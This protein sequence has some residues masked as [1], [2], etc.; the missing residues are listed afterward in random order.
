M[1]EKTGV[2]PSDAGL[3]VLARE[4]NYQF[5]SKEDISVKAVYQMRYMPGVNIDD[6]YLKNDTSA[7]TDD[8]LKVYNIV[9]PIVKNAK[10]YDSDIEKNFYP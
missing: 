1:N 8:E 6:A 2:Q 10:Q 4:W 7:L 3:P 9:L 5:I